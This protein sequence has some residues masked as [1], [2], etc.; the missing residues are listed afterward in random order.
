MTYPYGTRGAPVVGNGLGGLPRRLAPAA[1]PQGLQYAET[2]VAVS[3]KC[4]TG[5]QIFRG[6]SGR[7]YAWP[8][9]LGSG[10][11]RVQLGVYRER[12]QAVVNQASNSNS[13]IYVQ[14]TAAHPDGSA[15]YAAYWQSFGNLPGTCNF[16]NANGDV[17][18]GVSISNGGNAG[19]A[20]SAFSPNGVHAIV[21]FQ[22]SGS[23]DNPNVP[24]DRCYYR[25]G[26]GKTVVVTTLSLSVVAC[27]VNNVGKVAFG[28]IDGNSAFSVRIYHETTNTQERSATFGNPNQNRCFIA[29]APDGK[30]LVAYGNMMA[31][32]DP[33]NGDRTNHTMPGEC[34][35]LYV[36]NSGEILWAIAS[37][38]GT[39][40]YSLRKYTYP[41]ISL[42]QSNNNIISSSSSSNLYF[43]EEPVTNRLAI[44]SRFW[45]AA[46]YE[47]D[48]TTLFVGSA[49]GGWDPPG[50]LVFAPFGGYSYFVAQSF[51]AIRFERAAT[52][53]DSVVLAGVAL[54]N[55]SS[56]SA[57]GV[58]IRMQTS[59]VNAISA[60]F[61]SVGGIALITSG[62][63]P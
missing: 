58:P 7:A 12:S 2:T 52:Y 41:A 33:T 56:P 44:T 11:G 51:Q 55:I 61:R 60:D 27:A 34:Y 28:M 42:V 39:V 37:G 48:W 24:S 19:N 45:G 49:A 50:Q 3:G 4:S 38:S 54:E 59:G 13:S 21:A 23:S 6:L 18:D 62:L 46:I 40:N 31:V 32:Y 17:V 20:V 63:T 14:P 8:T 35:G 15:V 43:S 29:T 30:F 22:Y 53:S 26:G 1:A 36:T 16:Y 10:P 57:S 5:N 9:L 47:S 25:R